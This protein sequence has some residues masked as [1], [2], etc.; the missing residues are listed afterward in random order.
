[1]AIKLY[2]VASFTYIASDNID[3]LEYLKNNNREIANT[4][5]ESDIIISQNYKH[6]KKILL[7][8]YF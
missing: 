1:M 2:K 7:E 4:I 8:R 6:I 5:L 3:D